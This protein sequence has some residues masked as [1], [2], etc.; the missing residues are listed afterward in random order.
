MYRDFAAAIAGA[1]LILCLPAAAG[2]NED[3]IRQ[4][5]KQWAEAVVARDFTA[6]EK[7]LAPGLIYAHSTGVIETKEEYLGK[8]RSGRQRY[9]AIE[10]EKTTVKVY[11]DAAVAHSIVVMKGESA[12]EPFDSRLMMMHFWVKQDGAW[13]LAAH[14]TTSL[15]K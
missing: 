10:H 14:Q 3:A 2:A 12:G 6:L 5:E 11:G 13:R 4:A 9:D 15:E 8:L 1:L 7:I